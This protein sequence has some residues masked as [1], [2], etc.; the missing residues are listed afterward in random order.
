[1]T[2]GQQLDSLA[3]RERLRVI[4]NWCFGIGLGACGIALTSLG[5]A[6]INNPAAWAST[7][8]PRFSAVLVLTGA[9]WRPL[10]GPLFACG[11]VLL[12]VALL[13]TIVVKKR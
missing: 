7:G 11:A 12:F 13:L 4:R 9:G 10:A 5:V 3:R 2:P 1:M 6:I 8:G